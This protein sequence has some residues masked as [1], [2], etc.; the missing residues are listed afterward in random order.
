MRIASCLALAI[1]LPMVAGVA[2]AAEAPSVVIVIKNHR[3]VP[4]QV[5]VPGGK[6]IEL[7]VE[8]HDS[9]PEEFESTD[10]RREKIVVGNGKTSVWVGPLPAGTYGFFGDFHPTTAQGKLI[11]K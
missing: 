11:V 9:T 6:R 4:P 1:W 10:L 5:T 2:V 3:F 8:N 7:I